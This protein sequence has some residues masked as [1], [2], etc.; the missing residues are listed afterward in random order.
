[1]PFVDENCMI[2]DDR[3]ALLRRC[4]VLSLHTIWMQ[5]DR[6]SLTYTPGMPPCVMLLSGSF[7]IPLLSGPV[8]REILTAENPLKMMMAKA[9]NKHA[10]YRLLQ[11][12]PMG[13]SESASQSA[14]C[15]LACFMRDL[16]VSSQRR[17]HARKNFHASHAIKRVHT[18]RRDYPRDIGNNGFTAPHAEQDL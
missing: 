2:T 14:Y 6:R 9:K 12:R 18:Q 13:H 10:N 3:E 15:S 11:G 17:V 4:C 8:P 5:N 1:M 16:Q 7:M